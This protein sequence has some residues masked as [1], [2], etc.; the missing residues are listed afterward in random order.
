MSFDD[1]LL[2]LMPSTLHVDAMTSVS[3]DGYATAVYTTSASA[4]YRCRFVTKQV[5]V[6]NLFG[7]EQVANTVVWAKSSST[8]SVSDK[9]TIGSSTLGPLIRVEQY[10][11]EDGHHHSKLLFG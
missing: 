8:F 2:S 4:D 11:D 5:L 1:A 3:T 6:V 10:N 9:F 7:E